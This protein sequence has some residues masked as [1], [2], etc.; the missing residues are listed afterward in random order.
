MQS[1]YDIYMFKAILRSFSVLWFSTTF[2]VEN[3]WPYSKKD[4]HLA[5]KYFVYTGYFW[6]VLNVLPRSF[7]IAFPN[8]NNF[9]S[10]KQLA[11]E[12]NRVKFGFREH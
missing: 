4:Q 12:Q 5:L 8:F 7:V 2:N 6:Q 3:G 10:R 9:V 11:M 1:T